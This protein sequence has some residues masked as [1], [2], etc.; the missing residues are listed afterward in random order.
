MARLDAAQT[1]PKVAEAPCL[2]PSGVRGLPQGRQQ[3]ARGRMTD[4]TFTSKRG[5]ALFLPECL[6]DP[7]TVDPT[8]ARVR[9][10]FRP[11]SAAMLFSRDATAPI[12]TGMPKV[13]FA[14]PADD[15]DAAGPLEDESEGTCPGVRIKTFPDLGFMPIRITE[16]IRQ[17]CGA[18]PARSRRKGCGCNACKMEHPANRFANF[19]VTRQAV[20]P[21]SGRFSP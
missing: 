17:P 3:T 10:R 21:R 13:A 2:A 15:T 6:P 8:G 9:F 7:A 12:L 19:F 1:A 20:L 18:A 11:R 16:G 4:E 14:R 5:D